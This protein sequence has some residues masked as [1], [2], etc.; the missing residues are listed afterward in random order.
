MFHPAD[1]VVDVSGVKIGG[2]E[3]IVVM[4][5]PCS[6]E[7]EAHTDEMARLVSEAGGRIFRGGAYK[8]RTSPYAFQ[9]L[10]TEGIRYMAAAGK[11]Y[12]LPI[13]SE[14]TVSYT[15]L[16]VYKR[17]LAG[18]AAA[19]YM[20]GVDFYNIPTTALAQIDSS[21]G[22]KVAINFE[23]VKNVVGAFYQ[24]RRVLI[25]PALLDTLPPRQFANGMAEA[26]KAGVVGDE[27]LLAL[28]ERGGTRDHLEEILLRSLRFKQRI[29]EL[30]EKESG[31]RKLLNFGHT[32]G[33]GIESVYGLGGLLDVY[34]RQNLHGG[35]L[36]QQAVHRAGQLHRTRGGLRQGQGPQ[37][38]HQAP[39]HRD[40]QV[41]FEADK[42]GLPPA[43][44]TGHHHAV[45]RV[46]V[47][48]DG[49]HTALRAL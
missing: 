29:V 30:D 40:L 25:D 16:D 15:H 3:P 20:R 27:P 45:Q 2:S 7:S 28:L 9:G 14:L 41:G 38:A 42:I 24:P 34:K 32:I 4:G 19:C 12:G 33:H 18:F 39:D 11:K 26:V 47:V 43:Q 5:G 36:I 10:G 31:P 21:I 8:P 6:I 17:Q 23:G 1:T 48:A 22:G 46:D 35:P 49:D 44:R 37:Q 13:V